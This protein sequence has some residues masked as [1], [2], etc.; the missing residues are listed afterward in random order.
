MGADRT[1]LVVH[2]LDDVVSLYLVYR[3]PEKARARAQKKVASVDHTQM[4]PEQITQ[5]FFDA[6]DA[7]GINGDDSPTFVDIGS[8]SGALYGIEDDP[9]TSAVADGHAGE[10]ITTGH[11]KCHEVSWSEFETGLP[12]VRS[13]ENRR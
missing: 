10:S 2:C 6:S 1:V 7:A 9:A 11:L 5:A 12:L 8:P 3:P 13:G 4:L